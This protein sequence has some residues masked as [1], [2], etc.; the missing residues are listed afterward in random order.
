MAVE[1]RAILDRPWGGHDWAVITS[2]NFVVELLD[3]VPESEPAVREHLSDFDELLLHLL[4]SDLLR[5]TVHTFDERQTAVTD[6]LLRFADRCLREGD[7]AVADAVRTSFV[8]HFG[9][10]PGESDA[11]LRRWPAALRAEL[12]R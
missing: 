8:E 5:L 11:L 1:Q 9:A 7:N 4:M 3:A 2:S 12:G 10:Y 6:R